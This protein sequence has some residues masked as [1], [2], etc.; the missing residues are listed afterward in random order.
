MAEQ[1]LRALPE[2][3]QSFRPGV[4][5]ALGDTYRRNG[6]WQEAKACYLNLLDFTDALTFRVEAVHVY[7]ALADLELRQ[8][9]L[10]N[11]AGYWQEALAAIQQRENWGSYPL[12]LIG[13]VYIR[14][15]ELLYEWNEL[16]EARAHLARGLRRAELGGD[17][18]AMIAGYLTAG[19]LRLT[20]GDIEAAAEY[21][22]RAR[23]HVASAQFAHWTSRFERFQLE[24][25]LAQERLR[26]VVDWAD[27]MLQDDALESRP[28]SEI[29]QLAVV[30]VLIVKGDRPS[31]DQALARLD[32]LLRAAA[33]EG[34]A[35]IQ[36]EALALQ[37][38]AH[39]RRGER[40][41]AII[42]LEQSLRLAEPEGYIRLFADYGLPLARLL[43]ELRTR[44]VMLDYVETLLPAF[45]GDI[46][47]LTPG[48]EKLSEPLTEREQE[49][50]ELIAAG[51]TNREIAAQLV[52]SP[53][54]VKKHA[55][56]IYGKLGVHNRTEASA[57]VRPGPKLGG[58]NFD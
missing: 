20:E 39:W 11:A 58:S 32:R 57:W 4:Y 27:E 34:R 28:E 52:I 14:L 51:L 30:R 7:G 49:I 46:P 44:D 15:G 33:E 37:A 29:A 38:L 24:L 8:G 19:R 16:A 5:G 45:G 43:Q 18:R 23:S 3:D 54:T 1:A 47:S 17:V 2:A 53:E 6:R 55:G 22:E 21:L 36:I 40:T 10:R 35:G 42:V 31:V 12:P 50:L 41:E 13:W 25:W 9:Q 48:R 26:A 56:H